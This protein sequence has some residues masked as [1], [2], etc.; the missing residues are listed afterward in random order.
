[1]EGDEKIKRAIARTLTRPRQIGEGQKRA[2]ERLSKKGA[3]VWT[4]HKETPDTAPPTRQAL[5][6]K[7]RALTKVAERAGKIADRRKANIARSQHRSEKRRTAPKKAKAFTGS[8][9]AQKKR[10]A[11]RFTSLGKRDRRIIKT[12]IKDGR[13]IAH[14]ATKG[15]R[16][17]RQ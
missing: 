9:I 12:E 17:R 14:H 1:M 13:E 4:L 7:A 5:R 10:N 16:S 6:A 8:V 2:M 11:P 15:P 3:D